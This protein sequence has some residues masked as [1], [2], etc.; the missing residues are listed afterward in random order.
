M[1][2]LLERKML[3][4]LRNYPKGQKVPARQL[5]YEISKLRF[6]KRDSKALLRLAEKK[7]LVRRTRENY[8]INR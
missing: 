4:K 8:Y 3:M 7:G 6:T 5:T 2:E 1:I